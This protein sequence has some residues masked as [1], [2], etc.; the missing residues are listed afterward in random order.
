MPRQVVPSKVI[1]KHDQDVWRI[2][3]GFVPFVDILLDPQYFEHLE[4]QKENIVRS[5]HCSQLTPPIISSLPLYSN[6]VSAFIITLFAF[7][8]QKIGTPQTKVSSEGFGLLGT[9]KTL[10]EENP[11]NLQYFSFEHSQ[12]NPVSERE[13]LQ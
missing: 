11:R 8:C 6:T 12:D 2:P 13:F 3:R 7:K 5:T 9:L 10:S 4:R 1:R